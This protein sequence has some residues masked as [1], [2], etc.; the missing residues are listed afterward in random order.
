MEGGHLRL[1]EKEIQHL[2]MLNSKEINGQNFTYNVIYVCPKKKSKLFFTVRIQRLPES[3][4]LHLQIWRS[5]FLVA[6][7]VTLS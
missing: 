5:I 3:C 7:A 6:T 2:D 4:Q 1:V